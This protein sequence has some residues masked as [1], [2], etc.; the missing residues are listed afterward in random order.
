[1]ATL[2]YTIKLTSDAEPGTGLGGEVVNDWVPR[3]HR[4][5]SI[6]PA[7][8]VKG[9]MRAALAEIVAVRGWPTELVASV[10][11][12]PDEVRPGVASAVRLGNAVSKSHSDAKR[13]VTRTAVSDSG[14]AED[15]TLRTAESLS[16]GTTFEG[17]IHSDA[18]AGSTN[19]LAWRLS[20]LSITALGGGRNR[21]SGACLIELKDESRSPGALLKALDEAVRHSSSKPATSATTSNAPLSDKPVV[22][23]LF[24]QATSPICCPEIPDKTNV[25]ATGFGIPASAVQG[26]ILHRIGATEPGW[27][28][29]LFRSPLFRLWPLQPC[30]LPIDGAEEWSVEKLEQELPFSIRVSLTHRVAKYTM[31]NSHARD[32][33]DRAFDRQWPETADGAPLKAT[34]GVLVWQRSGQRSLWKAGDMPHVISSHGVHSNP[35]NPGRRNLFTVDA[36]APL[37]WRG[38][39]VMPENAA[40]KLID[41]LNADPLVAIGKSRTVRGLGRLTAKIVEGVPEEWRTTTDFTVLV[42]QSPLLLS[43]HSGSNAH[44]DLRRVAHEWTQRNKL[45]P[46]DEGPDRGPWANAGIQFGWNRHSRGLQRACR[47]ALP[48]SVIV[49]KDR[50]PDERLAEVLKLDCPGHGPGGGKERGFG[51]ICVHPGKAQTVFE[52]TPKTPVRGDENA[53]EAIRSV[54]QMSRNAARLPSPSQIRA[55]QQR[56]VKSGPEAA[57]EYLKTQV[58]RTSRIWFAWESIYEPC[59]Q[60][61]KFDR[62]IAARALETL[63]DL[64]VVKEKEGRR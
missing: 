53:A 24:F 16:V 36:M 42:V 5:Q 56:L 32:F 62:P 19:D 47:V 39:V 50:I 46:L 29:E 17:R 21:G 34:D 35:E 43:D 27:A 64:A 2:D 48:G 63:A 44:E 52:P 59:R 49:F 37:V 58:E 15:Q 60:L 1:M 26:V 10:F 6:I 23:R 54:L 38:L 3:D 57:A 20:L 22:V 7:S 25:I 18:E 31:A 12:G 41:S 4:G 11:G 28:D 14:V 9:L 55:V 33:W 30:S 40:K 61:L 13:L 51:A 45:P 8:H